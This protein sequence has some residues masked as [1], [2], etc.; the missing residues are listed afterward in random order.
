ERQPGLCLVT[1][2]ANS[3]GV[4]LM[5]AMSLDAAL[6][7]ARAGQV[8]TLIVLE[9]DL[10]RR[11]PADQVEAALAGVKQLLVLDYLNTP[12]V[13]RASAVLPVGSFAEADGTWVN[14]EGRAQR[15]YQTYAPDAEGP[16]RDVTESWRWLQQVA[17]GA[18]P[19]WKN[20]DAVTA[21]CAAAIPAL[22]RIPDAAPSAA[23][24]RAGQKLARQP[25][26]YSGRTAM[27]AHISVHEPRPPVDP[28]SPLSFS[29]EAADNARVAQQG[30]LADKALTGPGNGRTETA[31]T[32]P[33]IVPLVWMPGWN[34]NQAITKF[35]DEINGHLRGG[36][37]GVRLFDAAEGG[38][39]FRLE[40]EAATGAG[41]RVLPLHHIFGSEELSAKSAPVA[42]RMPPNYVALNARE[43]AR[44]GLAAGQGVRLA[45]NGSSL[46]LPVRLDDS[47]PDGGI[48]LPQGLPGMP[49]IAETRLQVEKA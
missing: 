48:G 14:Y 31:P 2:E 18:V 10:F 36:D 24:R 28:D 38:E 34:S 4:A 44:L 11:A 6:A 22:A 23:F 12:T 15:A 20:L 30:R 26:R 49:V 43:L 45:W 7:A 5:E 39:Y 42:E 25:H 13:Q 27:R 35:Q 40:F 9:N 19:E 47:L 37:P 3:L 17:G 21:D 46:S 8:D 16:M 41:L 33:N 1:P 32:R 29:M